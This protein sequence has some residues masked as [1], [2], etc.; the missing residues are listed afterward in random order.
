MVA[1]SSHDILVVN[2]GGTSTKVALYRDEREVFYRELSC[3]PQE[4]DTPLLDQL[5]ARLHPVR[6]LLAKLARDTAD[7]QAVV[8]R[9]GP[10]APVP[11]GT[12][13]VDEPMLSAIRRGEVMVEH[14]SLLGPLMADSLAEDFGCPAYI[15]DPV[16]VDEFVDETRLTGLPEIPRRALSHA[17]SIK[18]AA[19]RAAK[20]IGKPLSET[21]LIVLHLGSG[22]TVALQ[23][24]GKQVDS[25]DASA[26]GPMAP[27]RT[28]SLP[29]LDL[30]RLAYSRKYTLKQMEELLVGKG[31]WYAHLKT[32]DLREIFERID[33]GDEYANLVLEAT[34]LQLAKETAAM[35]A[36]V[37]G[38]IDAIAITGGVAL[39]ERFVKQLK[40]RLS[41]LCAEI[42]VYPG[43]N[44]ML[45]LAEGA[46]RVLMDKEEARSMGVFI[47]KFAKE[48]K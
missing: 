38:E 9:G 21:N 11:C 13:L 8:G 42:V 14:P 6:E 10:I 24:R 37:D 41:W 26:S 5:S 47:E 40:S 34:Y 27:T 36:V 46:L 7:I 39:S 20:A 16:S 29:A 15:V 17:L 25:T 2:P 44:E 30:V 23:R 35:A 43:Q 3:A 12:Y 45:A 48:K 18:D 22:F 33:A 19:R 28:G 31:G 32:A 1:K 4:D